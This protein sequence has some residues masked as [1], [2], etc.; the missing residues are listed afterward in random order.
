MYL[1]KRATW[2]LANR[3]RLSRMNSSYAGNIGLFSF[4][5]NK[6]GIFK[7]IPFIMF[8][9]HISPD[10][11]SSQIHD[12]ILALRDTPAWSKN[13]KILTGHCGCCLTEWEIC[14]SSAGAMNGVLLEYTA[15]KNFGNGRDPEDPKWTL[16]T[17]RGMFFE[18]LDLSLGSIRSAFE[19]HEQTKPELLVQNRSLSAC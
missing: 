8:C 3:G 9:S 1:T 15:W 6:N 12:C 4:P 7:A 19:A 18:Q 10:D 14:I 13:H 11:E 5:D 17:I 16:H 2:A